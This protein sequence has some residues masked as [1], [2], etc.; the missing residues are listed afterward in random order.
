MRNGK[1]GQSKR[2][3]EEKQTRQELVES[4]KK[5][6][7]KAGN[8]RLKAEVEEN[9]RTE[10]LIKQELADIK[11]NLWRTPRENVKRHLHQQYQEKYQKAGNRKGKITIR[12]TLQ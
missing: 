5:K 11:Q 12:I 4:K 1:E 8:K 2:V 10:K 6:Y 7:G 9:V 3:R